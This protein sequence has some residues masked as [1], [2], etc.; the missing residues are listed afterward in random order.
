MNQVFKIFKPSQDVK[1]VYSGSYMFQIET[2]NA[3]DSFIVKSPLAKSSDSECRIRVPCEED[4]AEVCSFN[5]HFVVLTRK[6]HVY[7]GIVQEVPD[8][9]APQALIPQPGDVEPT[10]LALA[11]FHGPLNF[12]GVDN[13]EVKMIAVSAY[14]AFAVIEGVDMD[15]IFAWTADDLV[16]QDGNTKAVST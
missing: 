15:H 4:I 16:G 1:R 8:L 11:A 6:G 2:M 3:G 10:K 5:E 12:A 13:D 9:E 7:H 14:N